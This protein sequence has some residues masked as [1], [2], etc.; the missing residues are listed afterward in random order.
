MLL[1]VDEDPCCSGDESC[2]ED[3]EELAEDHTQVLVK[4][5]PGESGGDDVGVGVAH[6]LAQ[7]EPPRD[8][9]VE[10]SD[11]KGLVFVLPARPDEGHV[12]R[13]PLGK[14][15]GRAF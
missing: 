12:R 3:D 11:G 6:A 10:K 9:V 7:S 14:G 5:E 15:R 4:E 1:E 13:G 2:S 8:V